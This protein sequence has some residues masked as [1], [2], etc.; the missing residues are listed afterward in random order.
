M[1]IIK[2]PVLSVLISSLSSFVVPFYSG[3][4]QFHSDA[5][6]I[7]LNSLSSWNVLLMTTEGR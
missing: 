5:D 4:A 6:S 1:K 7:R 3:H 2:P